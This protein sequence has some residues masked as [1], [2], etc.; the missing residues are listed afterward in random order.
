MI[1]LNYMCRGIFGYFS[2]NVK[3]CLPEEVLNELWRKY[4]SRK[5]LRT[6]K[7]PKLFNK[8]LKN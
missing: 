7:Y 1:C 8:I 6:E 3:T 4:E 5:R 2:L